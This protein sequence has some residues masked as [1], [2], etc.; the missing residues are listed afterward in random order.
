MES[1]SVRHTRPCLLTGT[2]KE[3]LCTPLLFPSAPQLILYYMFSQ[4]SLEK[5][6]Y[7]T[8]WMCHFV[9]VVLM[10]FLTRYIKA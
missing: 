6:S 8:D 9:I 10:D 2:T 3:D 4:V 7:F 1:T 5:F